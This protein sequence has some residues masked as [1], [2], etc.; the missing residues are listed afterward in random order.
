MLAGG[1]YSDRVGAS[2]ALLPPR[3]D[4]FGGLPLGTW[5]PLDPQRRPGAV[6]PLELHD[7][8]TGDFLKMSEIRCQY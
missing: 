8:E 2:V 4:L 1:V 6:L 3:P 5:P 7:R